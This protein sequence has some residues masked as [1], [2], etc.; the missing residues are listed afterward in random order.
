[1]RFIRSLVLLA[2]IALIVFYFVEQ[3][4]LSENET[5]D[6]ISKVVNEKSSVL[7]T[8]VVPEKILKNDITSWIGKTEDYLLDELGEP[9]RRDVSAYEYEWWIYN[10]SNKEYIQIGIMDHKIVTIYATGEGD[11]LDS[12]YI[13]KPY[14]EIRK[15]FSFEDEVTYNK[16]LSSYTFRLTAEDLKMRP[17]TKVTDE[18]F[19]QFYFDTFTER[20]SSIRVLTASTLLKHR[21]YE[22]VYRGDLPDNPVLSEEEWQEIETGMEQQIFDIT[23]VMRNRHDKNNLEWKDSIQQVAYLH[24]KDMAEND[25]FS[26][27][28]LDGS[29]LK[30][31][32]AAQEVFYISAGENIAAQYTDA[33]AAMEGWLNSEGHREALFNEAYTHIGVGVYRLYYTQNF[34]AEA[35]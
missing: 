2:I 31:R 9:I 14:E 24:S 3:N 22:I 30:E 33:P 6:H 23:N 21:P 29:G 15:E 12:Y 7:Q 16:G 20:L 4:G 18:I 13:G 26:H 32:L 5:I 8:K 10:D 25:Y 35:R 34:L 19:V 1:M 27:F 11:D 28:G 17:L